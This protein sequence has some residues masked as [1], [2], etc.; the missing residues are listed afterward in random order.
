[1]KL[2]VFILMIFLAAC[3]AKPKLTENS[4]EALLIGVRAEQAR[5]LLPHYTVADNTYVDASD[6]YYL[7]PKSHRGG[8]SIMIIDD[9]VVR[10]DVDDQNSTVLTEKNIGIGAT[11]KAVL[12]AYPNASSRPHPYLGQAGEYIE[13]A[14]ASGNALIFETELDVVARYRLGKYPEVLYIEGCL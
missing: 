12:N 6:C 2:Y 14:L 9:T 4:F 13:V 10:F 5:Q 8:L 7:Q 1:M 11:K 3:A